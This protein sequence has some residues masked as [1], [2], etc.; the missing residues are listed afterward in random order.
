MFIRFHLQYGEQ[1]IL[2]SVRRKPSPKKT[3]NTQDR[4]NKTMSKLEKGKKKVTDDKSESK[5]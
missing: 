5:S 4:K 3:E 1:L 2:K